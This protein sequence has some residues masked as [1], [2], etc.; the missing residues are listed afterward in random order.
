[1][2]LPSPAI[3]ASVP[4]SVWGLWARPPDGPAQIAMGV[5]V[6]LG[7]VAV[8]PRGPSW[9]AEALDFSGVADFVHLRRFV[10]VAS[11]SSA[12]LSLGYVAFYLRGGPRAPEAAAFWLQGRAM[13]HGALS[14]AA[15]DPTA[16]FRA[17][18]LLFSAP[19]RLAAAVAP[20][21][22]ALLAAGFLVGAP[23]LVGPIVA[24]SLVVTTWLLANELARATSAACATNP[25]AA[26]RLAAALSIVC[27]A[28]RYD[29]ADALPH[30]LA[31]LGT[32]AALAISLRAARSSR[33][34]GFLAAGVAL[35]VVLAT[36]PADSPGVGLAVVAVALGAAAT[37]RAPAIAW[38]VAGAAPGALLLLAANH[39]ATGHALGSPAA[40]YAAAIA[41]VASP[42]GSQGGMAGALRHLRGHLAE[43]ANVEPL[44]AMVL[45]PVMGKA[46]SRGPL[47]A[48]SLIVVQL[49]VGLALL[50][51][52][53]SA[54]ESAALGNVLPI[55]HALMGL[56]VVAAFPRRT[57]TA[58]T[59]TLALAVAGFALHTSHD[60][61]RLAASDGGRPRYEPD[62]AREAGISH[63]LLF[64]DDDEGYELASDPGVPASHGVQAARMLGDDHD[65]LLYDLLGHPPIHRYVAGAQAAAVNVWSPPGAGSD[66]WRFEAESDW[67]PAGVA[68]GAAGIVDGAGMCPADARALSLEPS[69]GQEATMVLELPIP[70]GPTAPPRQAWK[71][72]PRVFL[73]G[74]AGQATMTL[75]EGAGAP[76]LARWTWTD[77]SSGPACVELDERSVEL[78]SERRQAWLSVVARGG[79]VALDKTTVRAR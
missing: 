50:R 11:F 28:L 45:I 3:A 78:Q 23:M 6:V 56:A 44:A 72:V 48:A 29:T 2:A 32:A 15:P 70:G 5:A 71:V 41:S 38:T 16:S 13:A 7:V 12:F 68:G 62:V 10:T 24:A 53:A 55:E 19:D 51:P 21:Y 35:G 60:H 18:R 75:S 1:M 66:T 61:A 59:L 36:A 64:F 9:L 33:P 47:I 74:G 4:A 52:G 34:S 65:R 37:V 17:A 49:A 22:P 43:I 54:A 20:G 46:R 30:G 26:G 40:R 73:R 76:P 57:A 31:A 58:A 77:A 67:P 27:V 14:W 42:L 8:F 39:A 79:A 63:G 69:P 25:E